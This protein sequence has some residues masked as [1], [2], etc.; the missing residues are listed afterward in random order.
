MQNAAAAPAFIGQRETISSTPPASRAAPEAT[1]LLTVDEAATLLRIN[2]KTLYEHVATES[3][4]WALRFGRTIR[5]SREGLL[6]W[7]QRAGGTT[8]PTQ[9]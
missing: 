6:H 2:R 8:R 5:I 9:R 4:G 1:S 3:P 7:A